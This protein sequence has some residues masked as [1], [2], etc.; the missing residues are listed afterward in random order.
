M[1]KYVSPWRLGTSASLRARSTAQ[2]ETCAHVVHTFWPVMTQSSPSRPALVARDARSE[3]APGS[4]KSWHQASSLRTIGGRK[5]SRCSSVPCANRA[6]A[7]R[8]RPSG[9]RRPRFERAELLLDPPGRI[10]GETEPAVGARPGGG[11]QPGPAEGGVPRFVLRPCPDLAH[12]G[13][14]TPTTGLDPCRGHPLR[15]PPSDGLDDIVD[16]GVRRQRQEAPR[17]VVDGSGGRGRLRHRLRR[18]VAAARRGHPSPLCGRPPGPPNLRSMP[19][20]PRPSLPTRRI[21]YFIM[22]SVPSAGDPPARWPA[23]AIGDAARGG[24]STSWNPKSHKI[25]VC[26][27]PRTAPVRV[28]RSGRTEVA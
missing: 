7:A 11:H 21:V 17:V 14:P 5:R 4:L 23:D 3:P 1:R 22:S 9:F 25:Y 12:R 15:N 13:R 28:P 2:S 18:S 10:R 20:A 8:F 6:G 24:G 19:T 16:A 26:H 27:R